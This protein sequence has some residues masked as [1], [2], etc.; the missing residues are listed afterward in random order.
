MSLVRLTPTSKALE[1]LAASADSAGRR[2][3]DDWRQ[4][5]EQGSLGV[6]EHERPEVV[7]G[8]VEENAAS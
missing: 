3:R 5:F 4:V 2:D 1:A 8:A 7:L 6:V